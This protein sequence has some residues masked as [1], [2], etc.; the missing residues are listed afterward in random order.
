MN[1]RQLEVFLV[2]IFPR[3]VA[4]TIR[5]MPAPVISLLLSAEWRGRKRGTNCSWIT[6]EP[7]NVR[8]HHY[9]HLPLPKEFGVNLNKIYNT[10]VFIY[11]YGF[12]SS[13]ADKDS[14]CNAGDPGSVPGWG[15]SSGVVNV[16]H[17]SVL[18]WRIPWTED[19][20]GL[21]SMVSQRVRHN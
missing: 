13:S 6:L 7:A 1:I 18:A 8:V 2:L 10:Y 14:T 3:F 12:P 21:Q 9:C 4:L 20:G 19:P 5:P 15:R 11:I 17:S 16:T